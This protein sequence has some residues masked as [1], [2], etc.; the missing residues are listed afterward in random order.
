M[1]PEPPKTVTRPRIAFLQT[2][3]G[4]PGPP[5]A[6]AEPPWRRNAVAGPRVHL[7]E[8]SIRAIIVV[9]AGA[10]LMAH[11]HDRHHHRVEGLDVLIGTVA[12]ILATLVLVLLAGDFGH[13]RRISQD[14]EPH[15]PVGWLEHMSGDTYRPL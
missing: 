13:T 4:A 7:T 8:P 15:W 10:A 1:K 14:A 5:P 6:I 9:V 3:P 11:T 2:P 12:I